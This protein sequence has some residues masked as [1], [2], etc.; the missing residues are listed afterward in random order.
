MGEITEKI[1]ID[2]C[3]FYRVGT[4]GLLEIA[5][6]SS[7]TGFVTLKEI[8]F[9]D[10]IGIPFSPICRNILKH[11][12]CNA[13]DIILNSEITYSDLMIILGIVSQDCL[14]RKQGK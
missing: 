13:D 7:I 9:I 14:L 6:Q 12:V 4:Y 1:I 3:T 8:K 10:S 5:K 2:I 11:S